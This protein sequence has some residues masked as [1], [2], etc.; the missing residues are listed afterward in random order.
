MTT[1]S[2]GAA[3]FALVRIP[4][5]DVDNFAGPLV[6]ALGAFAQMH[7]HDV[8]AGGV[9]GVLTRNVDIEAAVADT[10]RAARPHETGAARDAAENTGDLIARPIASFA[11][12]MSAAPGEQPLPSHP[13]DHPADGFHFVLTQP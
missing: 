3:L 8:T 5:Q 7:Q 11:N 2:S 1:L 12:E 13:F 9:F 4:F 10:H 6:G